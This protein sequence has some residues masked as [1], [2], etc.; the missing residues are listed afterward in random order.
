MSKKLNH[1]FNRRQF[2]QW[3][4]GASAV[5]FLAACAPAAAPTGGSEE[6]TTTEASSST[7]S[8]SG[9]GTMIWVGHQEVSGLSP[10]DAGP[11]VQWAMISNIHDPMLLL[12]ENYELIPTL[13]ESY[14]ATPDG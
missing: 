5:A 4:G 8:A 12:D 10:N 6:G 1:R 13:A 7:E 9:G 2:L 14:E 3:T 11:T